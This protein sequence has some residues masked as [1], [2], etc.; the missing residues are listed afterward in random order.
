MTLT[1][2]R[3]GNTSAVAGYV[4]SIAAGVLCTGS[5]APTS[6]I[7]SIE[8]RKHAG[9]SVLSTPRA[10]TSLAAGYQGYSFF[11]KARVSVSIAESRLAC[12][13]T[14]CSGASVDGVAAVAYFEK[15]AEIFFRFA[16][17]FF[18]LP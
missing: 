12:S 5:C 6:A 11:N 13:T 1:D 2:D 17:T 7:D 18:P 14:N 15:A 9:L 10:T 4:W 3:L 16:A 8:P